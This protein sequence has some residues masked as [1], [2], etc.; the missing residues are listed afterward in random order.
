MHNF[1]YPSMHTL[2]VSHLPQLAKEQTGIWQ[3]HAF[4][5]KM[6]GPNMF[7]ER[8]LIESLDEVTEN[9]VK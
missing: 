5:S 1:E 7:T 6:S 2:H 4:F 9:I 8:I 3:K